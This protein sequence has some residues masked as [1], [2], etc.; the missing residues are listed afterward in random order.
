MLLSVEKN[1][2]TGLLKVFQIEFER[3]LTE[4]GTLFKIVGMWLEDL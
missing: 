4:E 2:E 1:I 3:K